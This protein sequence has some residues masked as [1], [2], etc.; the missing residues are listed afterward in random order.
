M[1]C[2][3]IAA[4]INDKSPDGLMQVPA[5]PRPHVKGYVST[6]ELVTTL[7]TPFPNQPQALPPPSE[8]YCRTQSPHVTLL[9][10]EE[11]LK[12]EL[13]Q[14]TGTKLGA[15]VLVVVIEGVL[16]GVNEGEAPLLSVAVAEA[17]ME[18]VGL[19]VGVVEG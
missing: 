6:G 5:P 4:L 16:D 2:V 11:V 12:P 7:Q 1:Q 13:G 17:V 15:G 9:S 10:Q 8:L 18:L 14:A 19:L 3:A